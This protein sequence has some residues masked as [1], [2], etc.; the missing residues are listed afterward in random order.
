MSIFV[1]SFRNIGLASSVGL[2]GVSRCFLGFSKKDSEQKDEDPIV[3]YIK[4]G[5]LAAMKKEHEEAEKFFHMALLLADDKLREQKMERSEYLKAKL[6]IYDDMAN[7]AFVQQ[8]FSKAENLYKE[9]MKA[10]LQSGREKTDNAMVELTIKLG[11]IYAIQKKDELAKLGYQEALSIMEEKVKKDPDSD[12]NTYALL[13]MALDSYGRYLM[14]HKQYAVAEPYI[15]RAESIATKVLGQDHPQRIVLLNDIA[16]I[17]IMR[18]N[19]KDAEVTLNKAV[20]IGTKANV[21]ELPALHSNLGAVYLRSSKLDEAEKN[22][23]IALSKAKELKNKYAQGQAEFCLKKIL[24]E[25][26]KGVVSS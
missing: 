5:R 1:L 4:R 15:V 21:P 11:T 7:L 13:G 6:T 2:L 17:Q 25:R 19:L 23:S 20:E 12:D 22:C 10:L 8:Q 24:G 26:M 18:E 9:T 3:L 16:T 14:V